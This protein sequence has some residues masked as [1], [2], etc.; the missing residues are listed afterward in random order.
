MSGFDQDLGSAN[1]SANGSQEASG[2]ETCYSLEMAPKGALGWHAAALSVI[3]LFS[4]VGNVLVL[5]LVMAYRRLRTRSV[6]ISMS[7]VV[8]DLLFSLTYTLPTLVT[9]LGRRWLMEKNG[10]IAFGFLAL[11]SLMTRW[12]VVCLLCVDRFCTVYFPFSYNRRGKRGKIL[13]AIFTLVVWVVPFVVNVTPIHLFAGFALRENIPVC[14][15]DCM[16]EN[17]RVCQL[18]YTVFLTATYI[19]GSIVPIT[20]Y[21]CLCN[22]AR[23]LKKSARH[24][25]GHYTIQVASGVL[26]TQPVGEYPKKKSRENQA[27]ITFALIFVTVV[28]T[29]TPSYL[30]QV[31]RAISLRLHCA[32]PIF[33]HFIIVEVF[34]S[35]PVLTPLVIMRDKNFRACLSKLFCCGKKTG[36]LEI[37]SSQER[38]GSSVIIDQRPFGSRR[39]S[40]AVPYTPQEQTNDKRSGISELAV[41]TITESCESETPNTPP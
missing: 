20:L 36:D 21:C 15:P 41:Y 39:S 3:L 11:D 6:V 37:A 1:G 7:M 25:I 31:V 35:A 17:R 22:K 14:L 12:F 33:V 5:V 10:C 23:K 24:K 27:N 13:M 29:G 26:V 28:L 18:Y 4:L 30:L 8:A 19:A 2:N 40:I 16:D 9:T 38:R 34:L 32:I